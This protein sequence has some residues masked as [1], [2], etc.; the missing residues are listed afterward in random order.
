MHTIEPRYHTEPSSDCGCSRQ[1][2]DRTIPRRPV[3][4]RELLWTGIAAAAGLG[5]RRAAAQSTLSPDAALQTLLDGNK[6]YVAQRLTS[7]DE[8]LSILRQKTVEQQ[9]PFAAVLS[10]ADSRVPVEIA[11]DQTIG[12]VFVNRVAGNLATSEI[13]ASLEYGAAVLGT[14]AILVL[15]HGSCG[16]VKAAIDAKAVPGQISQLYAP[17]R[18]AVDAGGGVL[19]AAIRENAKIQAHLLASASPLLAGLIN[20]GKLKVA[21]GYYDLASGAVTLLS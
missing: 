11:F 18:Q 20:Q 14:K 12:H 19:D 9:Q 21:A 15:G 3:S 13:I 10:C 1:P 7:F 4:R 8:D 17:L 2:V 5:I 6:R 16:A